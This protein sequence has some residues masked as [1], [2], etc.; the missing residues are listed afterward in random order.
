MKTRLLP[1]ALLALSTAA[2]VFAQGADECT[3]AQII[4]GLGAFAFD[5]IAADTGSPQ[6][7]SPAGFIN[8]DVWFRWTAP[9]SS[10][11][12]VM[13][14][15]GK[16]A[17]WPAIDPCPQDSQQLAYSLSP[18]QWFASWQAVQGTEYLIQIGGASPTLPFTGLAGTFALSEDQ[19]G[20]FG[21][22]GFEDSDTCEAAAVLGVGLQSNLGVVLGDPDYFRVTVPPSTALDVQVTLPSSFGPTIR[23]NIRDATCGQVLDSTPGS[24]F[25]EL[26][27]VNGQATSQE[28]VI[29]VFLL[30][31]STAGLCGLY[32][33]NVELRPVSCAVPDWLE[34]NDDCT[35]DTAV[36]PSGFYPDL[37]LEA[38]GVDHYGF[39]IAPGSQLS[40]DI[41]FSHDDGD[42][43]MQL[44]DLYSQSCLAFNNTATLS[45]ASSMTDDESILWSNGTG[46]TMLAVL[47]VRN[48]SPGGCAS[49]SMD[50]SGAGT[51]CEFPFLV[52]GNGGCSQGMPNST[53][54]RSTL[55][56]FGTPIVAFN[57]LLVRGEDLPPG[58]FAYL[59]AGRTSGFTA[60]PGG[61]Q[62][63]LCLDQPIGRFTAQVGSVSSAGTFDTQVDIG[64]IPMNPAVAA[65]PGETWFFQLWH[66][67][68]NPT[69]T[70]N[71]SS[72]SFVE[73]R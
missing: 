53:G 61:S 16:V 14:S 29:E 21:D 25:Q 52:S 42:L 50:L 11:Y 15:V 37:T 72:A 55:S 7:I 2:P 32:D 3:G 68:T 24:A 63:D 28:F 4:T 22:D 43:D 19:C 65:L 69:P 71:F 12:T 49:Y 31:Q 38:E 17:V 33:L 20:Q 47:R 54:A 18:S 46:A 40:A 56:F 62:G 13:Q 41:F 10:I 60:N 39:C 26:T 66:R 36:V 8:H 9:A 48:M 35:F 45:S 73:F 59:L 1:I 51:N 70:S 34:P 64:A 44:I 67:D 5:G 27:A 6:P 23:A 58:T 30:E 57:D